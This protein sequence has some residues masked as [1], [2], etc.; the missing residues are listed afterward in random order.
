M[1]RKKNIEKLEIISEISSGK[2][3]S[4][5]STQKYYYYRQNLHENL[6]QLKQLEV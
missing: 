3:A 1:K 4:T 5:S 2:H 6:E